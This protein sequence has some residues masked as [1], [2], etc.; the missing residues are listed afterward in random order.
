MIHGQANEAP[1]LPTS[2]WM[3]RMV[4][5]DAPNGKTA[6]SWVRF[7]LHE[8]WPHLLDG[9][10]WSENNDRCE[11]PHVRSSTL[12]SRCRSATW[13]KGIWVGGLDESGGLV[14]LTP[15]GTVT[16]RSGDDGKLKSRVQDPASSP[17]ELLKVLPASV[18]IRLAGESDTDQLDE[19]QDRPA[20]RQQMEG[21]VG[22]R[23]RAEATTRL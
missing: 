17:V 7:A 16:A 3:R 19:E 10:W 18:S 6:E 9:K 1:S 12:Q 13:V 15:H 21:L 5:H 8:S 11:Q 2:K 14:V 4:R 23:A 20:Q 22:D